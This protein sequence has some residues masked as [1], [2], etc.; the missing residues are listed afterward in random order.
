MSPYLRIAFFALKHVVGGVVVDTA[1]SALKFVER[2]FTDN[3]QTLPR[4]L[5][6]ASDRAWKTLSI[7]LAGDGW[8]DNLKSWL[9]P[10]DEKAFAEQVQQFLQSSPFRFD[11]SSAQ[12]RKKCLAELNAARQSGLLSARN[13]A[14]QDLG[15]EIARFQRYTNRQGMIDGAAQVVAEIADDLADYP[16]L[17]KLLRQPTPGGP[18]LFVAAFTFFLR[19]EVETDNELAHGLFWDGLRQFSA[20]QEQAFE[21]VGKA[22]T[23]LGKNFERVFD[24]LGRIEDVVVETQTVAVA[25]H[26][27]VLDMHAEFQR[28]SS[29]HLANADEVRRLMQEV[30]DRV[31]Q[32]GMQKGEVKAQHSFSI[33]SEVE[34]NA[35]EHLLARFRQMPAEQQKQFPALLN[36]LGKLQIGSGHFAG[37]R[38]TFL[39]V[40]QNTTE[41]TV[42]AEAQFNAYRAALEEK[43]WVDALAAIEKAAALD[44]QRFAPFPLQRYQA[45]R[46]LGA[47]GFGTAFLCHDRF[48]DADVVVKT[49]H[50]AAM[51]RT[52]TD[53]FRE[54][55]V[56]S[57]LHHP[58]IIGVRDCNFAD[59]AVIGVRDCNFA[60]IAD[61]SRP[62]IVMDYF[63]GGSLESFIQERGTI[64]PRDFIAVADQIAEGMYAAHQKN[65]LHRDLKP[66]NVL[67]RKEGPKWKVKIIDFGLA[68]RKQTIETSM[69]VRSAGNTALGD[70]VA[71]T[72]KYAPP[73]QMGELRGVKA[74]PY[75]DVYSFGKLCCFALFKT[76]EPKDRHWKTVP[77]SMRT[78]LK[79]LLDQCREE[80]LEHRLPSFDPVLKTLKTLVPYKK[81]EPQKEPE[82][83]KLYREVEPGR[84][85][86]T[87]EEGE[88]K[89]QDPWG[90]MDEW[91]QQQKK[92]EARLKAELERQR[93]EQ[94]ETEK[95][96]Q[97]L[98]RRKEEEARQKAELERLQHVGETALDQLMW[99]VLNRT[100]GRLKPDDMVPANDICQK[101][102]VP[103]ERA[104]PIIEGVKEQW[105][106]RK[107]QVIT[108]QRQAGEAKLR[109][110]IW[111]TLDRTHG[112]P[113]QDDTAA[114]R[115]I[116]KR[117]G[118]S[119]ELAK[120]ILDDVKEE[121][122]KRLTEQ[123]EQEALRRRQEEQQE[124]LQR[125]QEEQQ[126]ALRRQQ[127]QAREEVE[128]KRWE[129]EEATHRQEQRRKQREVGATLLKYA[130]FI[131][132]F[133]AGACFLGNLIIS[134]LFGL[135]GV[136]FPLNIA[137]SVEFWI[138]FFLLVAGALFGY[139]L[140]LAYDDEA[141][142]TKG[143]LLAKGARPAIGCLVLVFALVLG[144]LLLGAKDW[145]G[146]KS[147]GVKGW[148]TGQRK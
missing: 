105:K 19:R 44:A 47:G 43:K 31:I 136:I 48:F 34:R 96:Q 117:H 54:A 129:Q 86:T 65:V 29:L 15:K 88:R 21:Q 94:E 16:N 38:Q 13:I 95:K 39:A 146:I 127:E 116:C 110:L 119:A 12:F 145:K 106:H 80:E 78:D 33:R 14:P 50:V 9:A 36:G 22:L 63:P 67:V 102:G 99:E 137:G 56:L 52:M 114:A 76:T 11:G 81:G 140:A 27:A 18:P 28:I 73:E 125:Q 126:E 42:Q 25:T 64:S 68:L 69:A 72:V 60:D 112:K 142:R 111:E 139:L 7:A 71:G 100:Q 109:N 131:I 59:P 66:D 82:E 49:L 130:V 5:T 115:E 83:E 26:E 123:R 122:E 32:A 91:L 90:R 101:Y 135:I 1:E 120:W 104:G 124:A 87:Q 138:S 85:R 6:K 133:A 17:A 45:K 46:I 148:T 93:R 35:V 23:T 84:K 53:V 144:G 128:R 97:A 41:A 79:E 98:L 134:I 75:S 58:A 40:A 74:G 20:S 24:Q 77:D 147:S 89:H 70:S 57:Q 143:S 103:W 37:A 55:R 51:E 118:V 8:F 3:S 61:R 141:V 132:L 10:G 108:D 113:T 92:Q 62:Y 121:W 4:A 30:L 2:R 107:A